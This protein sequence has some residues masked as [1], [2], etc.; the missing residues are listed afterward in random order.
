M[1][2]RSQNV[3][4]RTYG[5]STLYAEAWKDATGHYAFGSNVQASEKGRWPTQRG[6]LVLQQSLYSDGC[7]TQADLFSAVT[8]YTYYQ[9]IQG[10]QIPATLPENQMRGGLFARVSKGR[11]DFDLVFRMKNLDLGSYMPKIYDAFW[12][13]DRWSPTHQRWGYQS[14]LVME[15]LLDNAQTLLNRYMGDR[16]QFGSRYKLFNRLFMML[17]L[18]WGLAHAHS[19]GLFHG[20]V[21]FHNVMTRSE[22]SYSDE[23]D[24]VIIDW[25]TATITSPGD[26]IRRYGSGDVRNAGICLLEAGVPKMSDELGPQARLGNCDSIDEVMEVLEEAGLDTTQHT[27]FY[28]LVAKATYQDG[29]GITMA[30]FYDSLADLQENGMEDLPWIEWKP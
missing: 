1:N 6:V 18:V 8:T 26:G 2:K 20:D 19:Q 23:W 27:E 22:G 28:T 11:K 5:A 16:E 17:E 29:T 12:E 30:Q 3:R 4:K 25:E 21:A 13:Y 14:I 10:N 7:S 24:W 9:P 15:N